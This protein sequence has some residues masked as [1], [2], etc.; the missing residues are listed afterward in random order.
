MGRYDEAVTTLKRALT[1]DGG[2][3]HLHLRLGEVYARVKQY[4]AGVEAFGEAARLNP[5]LP[6]VYVE[7]GRIHLLRREQGKAIEV[8]ERAL[9]LDPSNVH[10]RRQ[11]EDLYATGSP[12]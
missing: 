2:N 11:L 8:W 12:S 1:L 10:L 7:L 6:A 9:R 3:A 4:E 5:L